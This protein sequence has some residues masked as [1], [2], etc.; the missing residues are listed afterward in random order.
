MLGNHAEF[1]IFG[2]EWVA[3]R[4]HLAICVVLIIGVWLEFSE[5]L[6]GATLLVGALIGA[7]W[8]APEEQE[9]ERW[10]LGALP[11]SRQRILAEKF[12]GAISFYIIWMLLTCVLG[13]ADK[14]L[15]VDI[16]WWL[17]EKGIQFP[18][19]L[20]YPLILLGSLPAMVLAMI[21]ALHTRSYITTLAL[22]A[23]IGLVPGALLA[24]N[25]ILPSLAHVFDLET[26]SIRPLVGLL[27]LTVLLMGWLWFVWCKTRLR[28]LSAP[29]RSGALL[30]FMFSLWEISFLLFS[31]G[32]RDLW[33]ILTGH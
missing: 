20:A 7:G 11:I 16:I 4:W 2:K 10:W 26:I 17:K 3:R 21:V 33:F 14:G 31:T 22:T 29:A 25:V 1:E 28:E 24:V 23:V 27:G 5:W 8:L 18:F 19:A 30:L 12:V 32:W 9:P 13:F 6:A 15:R